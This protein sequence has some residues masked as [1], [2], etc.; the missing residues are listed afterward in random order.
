MEHA[1]SSANDISNFTPSL[2]LNL[3]LASAHLRWMSLAGQMDALPSAL[4][5]RN[6]PELLVTCIQLSKMASCWAVHVFPPAKDLVKQ[7]A[8]VWFS[9]FITK[10]H[11]VGHVYLPTRLAHEHS[12]CLLRGYNMIESKGISW[13]NEHNSRRVGLMDPDRIMNT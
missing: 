7:V 1:L 9:I 10:W 6:L 8:H 4:H 12:Y 13:I 11:Q 2:S 5:L 3:W